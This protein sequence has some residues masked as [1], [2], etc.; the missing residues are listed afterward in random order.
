MPRAPSLPTHPHTHKM[1]VVANGVGA[2]AVCL[3]YLGDLLP[4]AHRG[5]A[6]GLLLGAV[7][8][9]LVL[10]AAAGAALT[11]EA[12]LV[13]AAALLVFCLA[14]VGLALVESRDVHVRGE[15]WPG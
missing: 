7:S 13:A 12:A 8:G 11:P 1:Q 10:G 5:A 4:E 9:G 2:L 3:A 15:G 6:F 14:Y